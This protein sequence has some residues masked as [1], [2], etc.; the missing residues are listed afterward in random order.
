MAERRIL[1]VV[2][3]RPSGETLRGILAS[4]GH[5]VEVV[6]STEALDAVGRA[7]WDVAVVDLDG[8]GAEPGEFLRGLAARRP[9]LAVVVVAGATTLGR[10][11]GTGAV[12]VLEKPIDLRPEK[13]LPVVA[14]ALE[15]AAL[16]RELERL[17]LDRAARTEPSALNLEERERQ[18][19]LQ[20][21]ETTNWN[22]QAAA[23]LLGL[24]RPTLYSK[25]RKHGIPQKR[26]V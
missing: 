20:A 4:A 6:S 26:P 13:V 21:L 19:I 3:E 5:A 16:R 7:E 25:M 2:E 11:P 22:K 17:R 12:G 8:A 1:L 18:A 9:G 24:H 15:V 14:A 10:V 23:K